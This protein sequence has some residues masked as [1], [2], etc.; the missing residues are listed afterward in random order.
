MQKNYHL[1]RCH[2]QYYLEK[3]QKVFEN[4][5]SSTSLPDFIKEGMCKQM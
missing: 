5:C 4:Y 2:S 1:I 3:A